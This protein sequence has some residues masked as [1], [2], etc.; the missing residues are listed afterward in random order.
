[1]KDGS[2]ELV[3]AVVAREAEDLGYE[4]LRR[5][6]A[7]TPLFGGGEGIDSLSLVRLVSAV[8]RAAEREFGRRV[9]LADEKAMSMRHSPFRTVGTLAELLSQRL[10]AGHG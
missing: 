8:E 3:V 4:G 7:E 1:M 6:V 10:A 9:V 2:L 5:P